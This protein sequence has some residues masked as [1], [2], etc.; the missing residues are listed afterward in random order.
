MRAKQPLENKMGGRFGGPERY[1]TA[2]ERVGCS[3]Q[4]GGNADGRRGSPEP[5]DF[6]GPNQGAASS[7]AHVKSVHGARGVHR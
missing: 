5:G 3:Q 2:L 7:N 1:R 4:L 6:T